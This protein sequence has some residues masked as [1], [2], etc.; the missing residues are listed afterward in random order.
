MSTREYCETRRDVVAFSGR[1]HF[2]FAVIVWVMIQMG[3]DRVFLNP[4]PLLFATL[5]PD[6]DH[7]RSPI[8]RFIP[9]WLIWKHRTFTHTIWAMILFSI[10][11]FIYSF[12]WGCMFCLGYF[13]HLT[14]DSGTYTSI[15][16]FGKT[17]IKYAIISCIIVGCVLIRYYKTR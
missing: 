17:P 6:S 13:L 15:K 9:L 11:F 1:I 7:P 8:G 14:L 12:K 2:G 4:I 10:P 3:V 5:L 16:W